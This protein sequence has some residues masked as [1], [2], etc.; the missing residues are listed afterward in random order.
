[1]E[2]K[3]NILRFLCRPGDIEVENKK[4]P[5]SGGGKSLYNELLKD[6][7]KVRR[8]KRLE[9]GGVCV[10]GYMVSLVK[11]VIEGKRILEKIGTESSGNYGH[12]GR[13]GEVGGSSDRVR[14]YFME[15]LCNLFIEL[16]MRE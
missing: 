7:P 16:L 11:E 6:L 5:K 9:N 15:H 10:P 12:A 4:P 14:W 13:P 2:K 3:R 1:M 8:K